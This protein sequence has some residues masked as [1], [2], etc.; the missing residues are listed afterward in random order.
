MVILVFITAFVIAMWIVAEFRCIRW[1]RLT[2]GI[3]AIAFSI[4][5]T[6]IFAYF[7]RGYMADKYAAANTSLCYYIEAAI[8]EGRS[9]Q[10]AS[11]LGTFRRNRPSFDVGAPPDYYREIDRLAEKMNPSKEPGR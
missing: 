1:V 9:E 6:L 11:A 2:L 10:V 3:G 5:L 7:E 4:G 8:K